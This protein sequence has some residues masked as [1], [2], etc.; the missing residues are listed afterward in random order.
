MAHVHTQLLL[1]TLSTPSESVCVC[2]CCLTHRGFIKERLAA[3]VDMWRCGG[4][5]DGSNKGKNK[6]AWLDIASARASRDE[7][8]EEE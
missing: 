2:V 5:P 3:L 6:P 7:L 8:M 1:L 4:R